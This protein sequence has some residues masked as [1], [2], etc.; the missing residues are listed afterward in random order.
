M[1]APAWMLSVSVLVSPGRI[2]IWPTWK[3]ATQ[4]SVLLPSNSVVKN[5]WLGVGVGPACST[6]AELMSS[7]ETFT[8]ELRR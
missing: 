1:V 7:T 2:W 3:E 5:T 8:S 4:P 6:C